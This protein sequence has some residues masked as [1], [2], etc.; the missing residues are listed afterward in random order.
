MIS[1]YNYK[2]EELSEFCDVCGY[3]HTMSL[4]NKPTDGKYPENWKPEYE[5]SEGRTGFVIKRFEYGVDGHFINCVEKQHIKECLEGLKKDESVS[6]FGVT[7][8]D[9]NGAYQTQVFDKE[10]I[11]NN[12]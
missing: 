10:R 11:G 5:E 6:R 3:Y 7:F 8:K 4:K 12:K 9:K 2:T 1:E